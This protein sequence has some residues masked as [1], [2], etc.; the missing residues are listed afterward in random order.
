MSSETTVVLR[1][2]SCGHGSDSAEICS[3][4]NMDLMQVLG[5]AKFLRKFTLWGSSLLS[6]RGLV[7]VLR[8]CPSLV[9]LRVG[10]SWFGA[11]EDG[12][13]LASPSAHLRRA[14]TTLSRKRRKIVPTQRRST[15]SSPAQARARLGRADL[16]C[17]SRNPVGR[18]RPPVHSRLSGLDALG[19]ARLAIK[20][21][22]RSASRQALDS[23]R[24]GGETSPVPS[25]L[26]RNG[27]DER[28]RS[29]RTGV[30]REPR[31]LERDVAVH[32]PQ[33]G[34]G[35]RVYRRGEHVRR[36]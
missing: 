1:V 33:D 21:V 13:S 17:G 24:D 5:E 25:P 27:D 30:D 23:P 20:D 31:R 35:E 32:G 4:T 12:T 2:P 15:A 16:A 10:G 28:S 7:H 34:R 36:R 8:K 18:A 14:L 9:E 29:G 19:S 22:A 11:R 6:K 26:V 3:I